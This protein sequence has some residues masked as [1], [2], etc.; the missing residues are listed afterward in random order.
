PSATPSQTPTNTPT[1]T[2]TSTPSVTTTIVETPTP[3]PTAS[4]SP[5]PSTTLPPTAL[6]SDEVDRVLIGIVM[7]V[8]GIS[9]YLFGVQDTFGRLYKTVP[10]KKRDLESRMGMPER[11][12]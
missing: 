12:N 5:S 3:T 4:P 11:R 2:P 8:A 1:N 9:F 10:D 6:I 7:V